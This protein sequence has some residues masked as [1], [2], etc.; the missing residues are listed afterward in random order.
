MAVPPAV[1]H[2]AARGGLSSL[3]EWPERHEVV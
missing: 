3:L 2:P 1:S